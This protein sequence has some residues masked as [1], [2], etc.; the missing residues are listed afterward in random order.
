MDSL[1]GTSPEMI[2]IYGT[3]GIGIINIKNMYG[4]GPYSTKR[5]SSYHGTGKLEEGKAYDRLGEGSM[6]EIFWASTF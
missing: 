1:V 3:A 2:H 6:Y 4:S 5:R